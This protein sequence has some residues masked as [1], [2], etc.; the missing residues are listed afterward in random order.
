[1]AA[2]D[3]DL[4]VLE[5]EATSLE[6]QVHRLI[7]QLEHDPNPNWQEQSALFS[8]ISS[9]MRLLREQLTRY[10]AD[11]LAEWCVFPNKAFQNPLA[12][13]ELLRTR[14]LPEMRAA[15]E[16]IAGRALATVAGEGTGDAQAKT[17]A[18]AAVAAMGP[19]VLESHIQEYNTFCDELNGELEQSAKR[20]RLAIG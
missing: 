19:T 16:E 7:A 2:L 13:A 9:K 4:E 1:M 12:I 5:R 11:G 20:A 8:V 6:S 3:A 14:M 18:E 15:Q 10:R 17:E